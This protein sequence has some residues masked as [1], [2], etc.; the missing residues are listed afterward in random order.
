MKIILQDEKH[1]NLWVYWAG[2]SKAPIFYYQEKISLK[3]AQFNV[4]KQCYNCLIHYS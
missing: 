3:I 2:V 4:K 1:H